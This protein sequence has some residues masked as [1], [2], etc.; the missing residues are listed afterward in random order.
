[1]KK[2]R[3]AIVTDSYHPTRDGVVASIDTVN[4][5]LRDHGVETTIVAPD[6]GKEEDRMEGVYYFKSTS[7]RSYPGY[8]VPIYPSHAKRVLKEISPDV[9]HIQGVAVMALKG[10]VA[11]H[12]LGIPVIMTFHTMVGD[13][14]KYYSPIPIPQKTA[15]KLVWK[16]IGYLTRWVDAIIAPSESIKKELIARGVKV[17][18]IRVIPTPIDGNRFSPSVDGSVIRER[19]NLQGKRVILS[20]CRVSFEKNIDMLV[21][22]MKEMDEDVVLMIAGKGPASDSLKKLAEETGV[23]DRVIFTG[24]VSDDEVV[25]HYRACDLF[26]VA[27]R[28]ETQCLSAVE[29]MSCGLPVVAAKARALEDYVKEGENGY[30]FDDSLE[31]CVSKLKAGLEA[32]GAMRQKAIETAAEFSVPK[33]MERISSIYNDVIEMKRRTDDDR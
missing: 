19:Y 18:D 10:I 4:G 16:Y 25:Q 5:I 13:T 2:M 23:A 3:I 15:D 20:L 33:F 6:P 7:F 27:S 24:F 31:D 32:D 29:A 28:F 26:A 12:K 11:A 1:M 22:A 14:V 21:R 30:L 17:K 9:V 8:F